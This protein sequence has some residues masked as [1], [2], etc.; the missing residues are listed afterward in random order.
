MIED[1]RLLIFEV[2]EVFEVFGALGEAACFERTSS[3]LIAM[4]TMV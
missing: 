2:F 4:L 3:F 1:F